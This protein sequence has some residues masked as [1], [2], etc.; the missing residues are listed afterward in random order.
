[1]TP[2]DVAFSFGLLKKY[3]DVNTAGLP[4]T[5]TSVSGDDVTVT[6]SVAAVHEPA[7]HRERLHRAPVHLERRR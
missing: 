5:G 1:M 2:A 3:A 4:I 7:E 6:F